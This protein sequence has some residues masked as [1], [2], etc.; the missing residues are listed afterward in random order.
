[1]LVTVLLMPRMKY[2]S[3]SGSFSLLAGLIFVSVIPMEA[4][5]Y[6][7][8]V[9]GSHF[10]PA[11]LTIELGDTVVW[12]N[13]ENNFS[14]TTT[15]TLPFFN[16]NY[17]RGFMVD[18]F[19][20]FAHTFNNVG[21][22]TYYDELDSGTGSVTVILPAPPGIVLESPRKVGNQF[23]FDATGLTVGKTNVLLASTNLT[24]WTA[25]STNIAANTSM[26]FTNATTLS[27]LLPAA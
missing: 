24:A 13:L 21:T 2:I 26:T 12:E 22:F 16:A 25:I 19:D 6:N 15:S 11:T 3:V 17:W 14:H 7:V 9:N 27:P 23:L 5:T 20:T 4:A 1:M 8:S 18:Q 10:S